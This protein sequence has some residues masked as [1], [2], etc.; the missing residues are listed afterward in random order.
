M[1]R[2]QNANRPL[3]EYL[4]ELV[5]NDCRS[6]DALVSQNLYHSQLVYFENTDKKL[7]GFV[8]QKN[9]FTKSHFAWR[10]FRESDS[11]GITG[12]GLREALRLVGISGV[13]VP[14]LMFDLCHLLIQKESE[15]SNDLKNQVGHLRHAIRRI[16][17]HSLIHLLSLYL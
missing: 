6:I 9:P 7:L 8:I 13:H 12:L 16:P 14:I 1:L 17:S 10:R 4:I 2:L 11:L 3:L 15:P 5:S